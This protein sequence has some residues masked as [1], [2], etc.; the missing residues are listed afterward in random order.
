VQE[1]FASARIVD[2]I[3]VMVLV[4]AV[5][6]GLY[7]RRRG[8]PPLVGLLANLAAGAALLGALRFALSGAEWRWI[9]AMLFVA[10][11]AHAADLVARW[12]T[13]GEGR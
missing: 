2:L 6:I 5:A 4:E 9:A 8:G 11:I 13:S 7:R 1:L 3:L 12:R 10:L